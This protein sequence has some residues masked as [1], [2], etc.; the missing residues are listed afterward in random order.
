[1]KRKVTKCIEST[2]DKISKQKQQQTKSGSS[3]VAMGGAGAPG[4][5]LLQG[6]TLLIKIKF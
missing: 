5:H 6:G 4:R 1:M 2:S 3:G